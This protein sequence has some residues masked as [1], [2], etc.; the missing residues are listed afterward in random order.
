MWLVNAFGLQAEVNLSLQGCYM[1]ARC[2]RSQSGRGQGRLDGPWGEESTLYTQ[3]EMKEV[4]GDSN[5]HHRAHLMEAVERS[6]WGALG[7]E[8][9][10]LVWLR[11]VGG[12]AQRPDTG[13]VFGDQPW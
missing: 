13:A 9:G 11:L 8:V 1:A 4:N 2:E 12:E 10:W 5:G 6:V 3:E 7:I